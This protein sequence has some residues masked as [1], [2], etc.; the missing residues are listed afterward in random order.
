MRASEILERHL[1]PIGRKG[2][3]VVLDPASGDL[4]AAVSYPWP[5]PVQFAEFRANPDRSMEQD[6]LDRARFG[7][8]PPGSSFKI[9]TA[10]AALRANPDLANVT[11]DCHRLPDGRVGN[12]VGRS[13]RPIRDD[14]Q[15]REP[16]GT[17]DMA[18]GITVS[19]NA[20]FAQL[21]ALRVGAKNLWNTAQMFGIEVAHPNTPEKLQQALAQASYGQ[22]QV[23]A[24]PFQMARVAASVAA[25][26]NIPQG[27]WV[28]DE[29]NTRT[30]QPVPVL[31]PTLAAELG[32]YMRSV[33]T[34][35][36]GTGRMLKG[37][38][39]PI[40]GKTGTAELADAPSHAWFIG[41]APYGPESQRG[42]QR[43]IAF[44][45]LVEHG[46]YGGSAAA[47]IA[48]ELVA[49]AHELGLL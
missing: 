31:S 30:N 49:A 8:Y 43:R 22:G 14:V 28:I 18:R 48:G 32:G 7:L 25:G 37:N 17:V 13:K 19:C 44:A 24:S 45:V 9:V 21:G 41:F 46:Q 26:G 35:P 10:T 5:E 34:S 1:R 20:Y 40:A 33:V 36:A 4:L 11:F 2:A 47:P 42:S 29:T 39:I 16:H 15:D 12:Y 6:L 38:P 3:L 23:V 27:R